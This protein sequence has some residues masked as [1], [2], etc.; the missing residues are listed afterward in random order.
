MAVYELGPLGV[1]IDVT[2]SASDTGGAFTEFEVSGRPKAFLAQPHV[3]RT[4]TERHAVLLGAMRLV[5]SGRKHV[6]HAGDAME[7]PAGAVHA[8][9]PGGEGVGRVRVR[10]T[11]A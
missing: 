5:I 11:P 9:L 10:L 4:Q 1:V 2:H 3:H 8:Q 7:V 6:L